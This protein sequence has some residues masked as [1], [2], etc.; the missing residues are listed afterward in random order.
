M[1]AK[2]IAR[3]LHARN[4][5]ALAKELITAVDEKGLG[6]ALKQVGQLATAAAGELDDPPYVAVR[7]AAMLDQLGMTIYYLDSSKLKG[8]QKSINAI[9]QNIRKATKQGQ[10]L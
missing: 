9:A 10:T 7:V 6:G 2:T 8:Q 1:N 5:T 4:Q 3:Q